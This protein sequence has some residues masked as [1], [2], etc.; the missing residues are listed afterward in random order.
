[1][2]VGNLNTLL[3]TVNRLKSD[4][5]T[6]KAQTA[7]RPQATDRVDISEA[8]RQKLPTDFAQQTMARFKSAL[9][10]TL[11]VKTNSPAD[12]IYD[13]MAGPIEQFISEMF[14]PL[15]PELKKEF[16]TDFTSLSKVSGGLVSQSL[17]KDAFG[18]SADGFPQMIEQISQALNSRF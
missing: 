9:V 16:M 3:G 15:E 6:I 1:M 11:S 13:V 2:L 18:G 5:S 12:I 10:D 14:A 4:T 17:V 7:N 8:A